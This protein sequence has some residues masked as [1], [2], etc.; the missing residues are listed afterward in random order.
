MP[1]GKA[2]AMTHDAGMNMHCHT[3]KRVVLD[4]D[5]LIFRV[6]EHGQYVDRVFVR[7]HGRPLDH[8]C[9][10][11]LPSYRDYVERFAAPA[12]GSNG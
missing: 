4:G 7:D 10:T 1:I 6:F 9:W 11:Q 3:P 12:G 5:A 8:N 2:F